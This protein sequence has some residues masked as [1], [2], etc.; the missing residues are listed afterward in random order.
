MGLYG[1]LNNP[2]KRPPGAIE[3]P[4]G[5]T[6]WLV[7]FSDG[8]TEI[9]SVWRFCNEQYAIEFAE[10]E[11]PALV[12]NHAPYKRANVY[13]EIPVRSLVYTAEGDVIIEKIEGDDNAV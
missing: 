2:S 4:A 13:V 3:P 1:Q 7:M 6:S 10:L 5:T 9:P 8:I 12:A 11:L